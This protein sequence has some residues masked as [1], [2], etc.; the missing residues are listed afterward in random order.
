MNSKYLFE[1]I[2][3]EMYG[4]IKKGYIYLAKL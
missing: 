1:F 2:T 4:Y 3:F